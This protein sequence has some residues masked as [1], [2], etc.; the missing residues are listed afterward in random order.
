MDNQS[1]WWDRN[2]EQVAY[3]T[4]V[5]AAAMMPIFGLIRAGLFLLLA[6]ALISLTTGGAIF[7]WPLPPGIPLWTGVLALVVVYH[8]VTTP[9]GA[10]RRAAY[11]ASRR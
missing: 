11:Y 2:V 5:L 1:R 3:T 7:G 6:L 8:I 10:A 9:L 4:Q